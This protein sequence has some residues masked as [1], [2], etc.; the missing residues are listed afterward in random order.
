MRT[1]FVTALAVLPAVVLAA[2]P[3]QLT[4][5]AAGFT[6]GAA[7][8][9]WVA[10]LTEVPRT[11]RTDPFVIRA[12]DT[13]AWV[14]PIPA[15]N[16]QR[17]IQV[18]DS[19]ALGVIGQFG[20]DYFPQY[21]KLALH[22]VMILRGEQRMDRTASVSIRPLQRETEMESGVL[23]G[24]TTLQLLL[25][26]VRIG[27]TLWINYTIEGENPVRGKT[28]SD[29][30][31]WDISAPIELKRL[32]VLH[33]RQRPLH[34][35]QLGD[36]QTDKLVPQID[37]VDGME[38]IRF[39]GRG[40]EATLGEASTPS[41]YFPGRVLQFSEYA[42][43]QAVATW[44]NGL[45]PPVPAT[46]RL[47]ALAL[48]LRKQPDQMARAAA[49]LHWVQN[50]IRYFSVSIGENAQRPHAPDEVLKRRYGDCKDK[51]YLLISLLRELGVTARPVLLSADAPRL[52]AKLLATSNWFNHVIVQ[53][54]LDGRD[55]YVDPTRTNQPEPLATMPAAF[56]GAAVLVV[57]KGTS[58]LTTLPARDDVGPLYEHNENIVVADFSGAATLETRDVYRGTYAD[59]MRAHFT[60]L[61]ASEQK[62][63]LLADYEK[64]FPGVRMTGAP[65]YLDD[66]ANN[67]VDVVSYYQVPDAVS[68]T[69][70][71]YAIAFDSK[72]IAG[73]IGL[74]DKLV[75][76][77]PFALSGGKFH[78]RY[79]LRVRWPDSVRTS[80]PNVS[81]TLDNPFFQLREEFSMRGNQIDHL[82]DYKVKQDVIPAA[83]LVPLQA[84][85][86]KLLPF[87]SGTLRFE[88]DAVVADGLKG[89]SYRDLDDLR[90]VGEAMR[91]MPDLKASKG[92]ALLPDKACEFV[93]GVLDRDDIAGSD[94]KQ[95]SADLVKRL[96][97]M[98]KRA[99]VGTCMGQLAFA[100]GDFDSS[101]KAWMGESGIADDS[102]LTQQL[103]WS[104]FYSGDSSAALATM[105]RYQ[106]ARRKAQGNSRSA[107][108]IASHIALLQRAQ[109]A[110][111][112]ELA[113]FA[114][115]IPDGP[116]PRPVLAMQIGLI[117]AD[118]LIQQAEAL[119]G[120]ASEL[121]LNEAWFYIGQARLAAQDQV[122]AA[123]AFRWYRSG[124]IRSSGMPAQAMAELRRLKAPN[125]G[126]DAARRALRD[127]DW[128]AAVAAWRPGAVA[129]TAENQLALGMAYATGSGVGKDLTQAW[130]WIGLA[131]AQDL[132]EAMTTLGAMH[133]DGAGT[134]AS[135]KDAVE[136]YR[137]AAVLDQPE[138][139]AQLAAHY[140]YGFGVEMDM[141]QALRWYRAAAGQG[142]ASAMA[143][144][145]ELY[146]DGKGVPADQHLAEY[147]TRRAAYKGNDLALLSLGQA[148]E[149]G[150]WGEKDEARAATLYRLAAQKGNS[151]AQV[152]L[153][154]VYE[155][156]TGVK[157]S[158]AEANDW[159]AKAAEAGNPEGLH[160][161]AASYWYG[162]GVGKDP[163]KA[164]AL[165]RRAIAA[166]NSK[167]MAGLGYLYENEIDGGKQYVEAKRLYELAAQQNNAIAEFNLALM[168]V[169]GRG[170]AVDL[171]RARY[172]YLRAAEHGDVDAQLYVGAM[173]KGGDG[174][175]VDRNAA[176]KWFG[177]AAA[178]GHPQGQSEFGQMYMSG[179][180]V[181]RDFKKAVALLRKA[182]DKDEEM[183]QN[184][185][186]YCY[187]RG[188]GVEKDTTQALVWYQ[189][190]ANEGVYAARVRLAELYLRLKQD[191]KA[192]A[193]FAEANK[194]LSSA[195]Q[196]TVAQYYMEADDFVR[197]EK[198]YLRSLELAE[199]TPGEQSVSLVES[200]RAVGNF[201]V[202]AGRFDAAL[203]YLQRALA[204]THTVVDA[205]DPWLTDQV[206]GL[207]SLYIKSRQPEKAEAQYLQF[208]AMI[209]KAHGST[210]REAAESRWTV[211]EAY[212]NMEQ[213]AK[214]EDLY[215]QA[216][217]MQVTLFG[218]KDGKTVRTLS[219]QGKL[220][221]ATGR[222]Q[223]AENTL[224]RTL[225]HWEN[226]GE[227]ARWATM[228]TLMQLGT[229]HDRV[230]KYAQAEALFTRGM[231]FLE[232]ASDDDNV[233]YANY[234]VTV[235]RNLVHL[236]KFEAAEKLIRQAQMLRRKAHDAEHIQ[237][238]LSYQVLGELYARQK[239][240]AD[241][242]LQF[243]HALKVREHWR[244]PDAI[245]VAESLQALGD[246]YNSMGR[247]DA[248]QP[249]LMRALTVRNKVLGADHPD[250]KLTRTTLAVAQGTVRGAQ[251]PVA[252]GSK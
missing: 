218:E 249:V 168:Y 188:L 92:E 64:N 29:D 79:R 66:S 190:A 96:T 85:A 32:T 89:H 82:I 4:Q 215:K 166:G 15:T 113:Q 42:D 158:M 246:L 232:S 135:P 159:Y 226:D 110:L 55:Y 100:A 171:E 10:L 14:G 123:R 130:H 205:S 177:M 87:A 11:E 47:K 239:R 63:E 119:S 143:A 248:A 44:A 5:V 115:A 13:Q 3:A 231:A 93:F 227:R 90:Q 16:Y 199:K 6:R 102:P 114:R 173:Y 219:S 203:P 126:M 36:F 133:D 84:E 127:N 86:K 117:N 48:E 98:G 157:L 136:W 120:D 225:Q 145:G 53:I 134:A 97:A 142:H 1:A 236:D 200:L 138:A 52:P 183:A 101:T 72:I 104:Q 51:S 27:D 68:H 234:L 45:F 181:G 26:D 212:V 241:A 198:A 182:A 20:I 111:P 194:T 222:Y 61:S 103:A 132:P 46:P 244:G 210:S 70:G 251:A 240:F 243:Q 179:H 56:P 230:G 144:L 7:L 12:H 167:S 141:A 8:P 124:G 40:L 129:G 180:G 238:A 242:E 73:S 106:E 164:I 140:R 107:A 209:D 49:A 112:A 202:W 60:S 250:S 172:W 233:W 139:Q 153:G 161:L 146:L 175:R 176:A 118:Q 220:Y 88:D 39:E 33:P 213:F 155:N 152:V 25:D 24:A 156:G 91:A 197:A 125:P 154:Y 189:K 35:R 193:A 121:A 228:D 186:G 38:R 201:H 34:W 19:S 116:W 99:G 150:A 108:D 65:K 21:Q 109:Q 196:R 191:S 2:P 128:T 9:K 178:Q 17:A 62:N 83:D 77:Y 170:V 58:G 223:E 37:I 22:K 71:R 41:D 105:A 229:L 50:D 76:Q 28:W 67:R 78:G 208:L 122:G 43:W 169:H 94:L 23:G 31:S 211:A 221:F 245:E 30:F 80:L 54:T 95:F 237:L 59:A 18:N 204:L 195:G 75:R 216:Y 192:E 165:Y 206:A 217:A 148:Y 252:G 247:F 147:W 235:A 74:P 131:A 69:D 187:E 137:K 57:D 224:Q 81:E 207:G 149:S 214:A 162:K 174:V 184:A 151:N 185:L 160:N 163:Q